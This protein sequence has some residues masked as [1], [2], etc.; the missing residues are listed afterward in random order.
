MP[1]GFLRE[2]DDDCRRLP[3]EARQVDDGQ[4]HCSV[5]LPRVFLA[6]EVK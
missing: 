2:R 6:G 4:A 1:H 3:R 5:G